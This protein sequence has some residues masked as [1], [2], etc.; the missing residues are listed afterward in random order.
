[1]QRLLY[2]PN[3]EI[4]DLNFLKF[5]LIYID[6]IKPIIPLCAMD[7]LSNETRNIMQNTNLIQPLHPRYDDSQL[8]S[9]ATIE[10]LENYHRYNRFSYG[11]QEKLDSY[12]WGNKDYIL[13]SDKYSFE[14]ENYCL[15]TKLAERCDEGLLLEQNVAYSYM[16]ILA[17][18]ISK[19]NEIDMITDSLKYADIR[20]KTPYDRINT[21]TNRILNE[22]EREIQFQIP[23]DMRNIPLEQFVEL[24]ADERFNTARSNFS[25]ELNNVLNMQD[26]D[27]SRVDL[28]DY[29]N[30]KR[31]IYGLLKDTFVSCAAVAVGVYSF[32]SAIVNPEKSLAF[33]ANIGNSFISLEALKQ[34]MTEG[35]EYINQLEGKRQ[36]RKYL[37]RLNK[38]GLGML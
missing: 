29:L 30:C 37:A 33:F 15:E 28:Y 4:Q 17:D 11:K 2:Y 6:E 7:S 16:S 19:E 9:R 25:R 21:R 34:H 22:I 23:V 31:E 10:F 38:I 14:F 8:A 12:L 27:I 1:M 24:R 35:R 20:L 32:G 5:A 13:Y 36:A 3:F 26:L 18:I